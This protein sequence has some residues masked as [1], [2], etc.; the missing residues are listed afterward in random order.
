M[1]ADRL[2]AFYPI[3]SAILVTALAFSLVVVTETL[4]REAIRSHLDQQT[5]DVM[6]EIFPDV[7]Y[8][9]SS[10]DIYTVFSNG[11]AKVGYAFYGQG[12]GY[13]GEMLLMI[14]LKDKETIEGVIVISNRESPGYWSGL[15]YSN[16]LGQFAG[17]KIADCSLKRY[18]GTGGQVNGVTGATVSSRAVT[19]AVRET[20]L[21]KVKLIID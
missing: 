3:I 18:G 17:L 5:L 6:Q 2:R 11:G 1:K 7:G 21:A 19:D 14:G 13:G 10:N 12:Y 20:S 16:F 4:T 9:I 8:Y 15:I